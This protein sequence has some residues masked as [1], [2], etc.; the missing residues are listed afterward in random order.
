MCMQVFP[1]GGNTVVYTVLTN[2][3]I[4]IYGYTTVYTKRVIKERQKNTLSRNDPSKE[5]S[6]DEKRKC[7]KSE[8]G[9]MYVFLVV[10]IT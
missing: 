9:N 10:C 6:I 8:K 4:Y 1:Y 3:Y 7:T 2:I 5:I